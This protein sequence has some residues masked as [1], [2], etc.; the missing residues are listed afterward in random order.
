MA[1]R[2]LLVSTT[3]CSN[4]RR[5]RSSSITS[6]RR[7]VEGFYDGHG[8]AAETWLDSAARTVAFERP[9]RPGAALEASNRAGASQARSEPPLA[10]F[11]DVSGG[12]RQQAAF[13][14]GP[15][16]C[17]TKPGPLKVRRRWKPA[18]GAVCP[19]SGW[20]RRSR[21]RRGQVHFHPDESGQ[22]RTL[23]YNPARTAGAT[24]SRIVLMPPAAW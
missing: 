2:L 23:R 3:G 1:E 10:P 9:R 5:A 13:S 18:G 7:G 24:A 22:I 14:A 19:S 20:P 11:G 15:S 16:S 12:Q 21:L 6:R 17:S 4:H 8:W